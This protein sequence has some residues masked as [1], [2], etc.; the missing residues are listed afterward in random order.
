MQL[1]PYASRDCPALAELFYQTVHRV[2]ARDYDPEQLE[3]WAPERVDLAAWDASFR[4]HHTRIA[5]QD[6]VIWGF[7]DLGDRDGAGYLD[8]LYVRWD[9]QGRGV[10]TVLCDALER[11]ARQLGFSAI[12]TDASITAKPFFLARGYRVLREQ[13]VERRGVWLTNFRMEKALAS[14]P[15]EQSAWSGKR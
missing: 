9:R 10:A 14:A 15:A 5:E 4:A 3:A 1:R 7:A 13:R 2:N 8:R 11:K 12:C 6:G